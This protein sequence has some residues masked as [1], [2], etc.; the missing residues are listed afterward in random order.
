MTKVVT[1]SLHPGLVAS[2][3]TVLN[4]FVHNNNPLV[5]KIE[6]ITAIAYYP[7]SKQSLELGCS[8]SSKAEAKLKKDFIRYE[9]IL[10]KA[11]IFTTE[12]ALAFLEESY[13]LGSHWKDQRDRA[14][15]QFH[16]RME[17]IEQ[18]YTEAYSGVSIEK[19]RL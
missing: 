17:K 19:S 16:E 11:G 1:F 4:L 18:A 6:I 5:E 3:N 15:L 2:A 13:Q 9:K 14:T 7:I 8:F 12:D 10:T